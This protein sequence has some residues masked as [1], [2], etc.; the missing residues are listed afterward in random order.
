MSP[1]GVHIASAAEE[2]NKRADEYWQ[3][4]LDIARKNN[5]KR[6]LRCTQVRCSGLPACLPA[7]LEG[8]AGQFQRCLALH[9]VQTA[10]AG[11]SPLLDCF[12]RLSLAPLPNGS[13]R[14]W[15]T[16]R[17]TSCRVLLPPCMMLSLIHFRPPASMQIMGRSE[18][19]ELSASQV[20][21]PCMQAAD[22]FFLKVR[23]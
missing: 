20:F 21:Y 6:I 3:L 4:V 2:I 16:A 17:T 9:F 1:G 5:L 23:L 18:N 7:V 14:S 10:R 11:T 19:D 22:I 15:G 12:I 13:C 8:R